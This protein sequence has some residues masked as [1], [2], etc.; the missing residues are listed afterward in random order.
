MRILIISF[1]F[2]PHN[3]I[4]AVRVGKTAKYLWRGGHDVRVL[5]GKDLDLDPSL[6]LEIPDENVIYTRWTDVDRPYRALLGARNRIRQGLAYHASNGAGV[7]PVGDWSAQQFGSVGPQ[8][9]RRRL[10][11]RLRLLYADLFHLPDSAAG[12]RRHAVRAGRVLAARWRPDVILASGAPWTSL[13]VGHDLAARLGVPWVAELRDLWSGNHTTF[14]SNWRKKTVDSWYEARVLRTAAGLVTVSEPLAAKL[15]ARYPRQSVHVVL[16][17][18]DDEDYARI[19]VAER[20]GKFES[21]ASNLADAPSGD[22]MLRLLYTGEINRD[23]LPLL[24]G[25]RLL[26]GDASHVRLEIVGPQSPDVQARYTSI[27]KAYGVGDTCV[28]RPPVPHAEASELQQA[29]DVLVLLLHDSPNDAGVYTGK[30]FEYVGA[31]RPI[32]LAGTTSGVAAELIREREIGY[33]ESAPERIAARIR[34]WIREKHD[35][36]RIAPPSGRSIDDLSRASQTARYAAILEQ[37]RAR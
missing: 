16:N 11:W 6:A 20:N 37:V 28:W 33:A 9:E 15:R 21:N 14:V 19:R 22:T 2:P 32:L 30:L 29:A 12:W 3:I 10:S 27:A 26:A 1:V 13:V 18:F 31:R 7:D 35:R 17:G 34:D 4:G 8:S 36:G 25:I 5:A 23:M 24:D